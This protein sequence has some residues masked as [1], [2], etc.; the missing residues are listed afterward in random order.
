MIPNSFI[1]TLLAK[2]DIVEV[3]GQYVNLKKAGGNYHG[4]C[5]FHSEDTPSFTVTQKKQFYHCF[6][7]PAHG[8]AIK[9]VMEH[10]KVGFVEAV[11]QLAKQ[12][13][14]EMV[15]E[16]FESQNGPNKNFPIML[17]MLQQSA[18]FYYNEL[19]K[20]KPAINYLKLR[21][22]TGKTAK[23][24]GLGYA[25][26]E[27]NALKTTF[28]DYNN[29]LLETC[30]LVLPKNSEQGRRDFFRSRIMFPIHNI[31]GKIIGFGGRVTENAQPKYLNS[32]E[33]PLFEKGKEMYG[34]FR[35]QK[36]IRET[37]KA[38]VVEGYMDVI[39][40]AQLGINNAV[41]TLGTATTPDHIQR[42]LRMAD[43][44]VFCFDG[45]R[46]GLVAA[47]KALRV[48]LPYVTD[49]KRISFIF[50]PEGQDPDDYIRKEG[51]EKFTEMVEKAELLLDFMPRK[52]METEDMATAEG[53]ISFV[54]KTNEYYI[55]LQTNAPGLAIQ[56]KKGVATRANM[57][58]DE[59]STVYA[60]DLVAKPKYRKVQSGNN[61]ANSKKILLCVISK[62][63][64]AA[65]IDKKYLKPQ[66]LDEEAI[67]IINMIADMPKETS[68]GTLIQRFKDTRYEETITGIQT[69]LLSLGDDFDDSAEL[70]NSLKNLR[71]FELSV[72]MK[73]YQDKVEANG[74]AS[75]STQ[76]KTQFHEILNEY[77]T[78]LI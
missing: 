45:D 41:A 50:L 67:A 14:I 72:Q 40:L 52:L 5:P 38:I 19:K 42:L 47:W 46:A 73:E 77:T 60:T 63:G 29:P 4:L 8:N 59:V 78:L 3:I 39:A 27:W 36:A 9:F 13:N 74:L 16:E 58:V 21:G 1:E 48:L 76:D 24:F 2:I 56:F 55:N 69:E 65:E 71:L 10:E 70:K 68:G 44:I 22:I 61:A 66:Y 62:T 28:N 30:G 15:N 7:C 35:A 6:G 20:S 34:L 12:A 43:N 25:P 37:N 23:E 64:L 49:G 54:K 75:L 26:A 31:K 17:D 33:T 51:K 57:T 32:P 11:K 53:R 18:D